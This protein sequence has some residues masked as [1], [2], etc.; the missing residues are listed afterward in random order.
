MQTRLFK[1]IILIL[2]NFTLYSC[3]SYKRSS[4]KGNIVY[5]ETFYI[6]DSTMQYFIK[7]LEFKSTSKLLIDYTFRK[8]NKTFS[9]VT[10]NFSYV[11]LQKSEIDTFLLIYDTLT[12]KNLINKLM[13]KEVINNSYIYRYNSTIK[14]I[15]LNK[16]LSSDN[17]KIKIKDEIF[18]PSKSTIKKIK[19]IKLNLFDFE[20]K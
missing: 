8:S 11:G 4:T 12:N 7:P 19:K 2:F 5:Y 3:I 14:Y 18:L 1:I 20:L 15:D 13:Y 17:Y 16:F 9:D 10:M 6:N